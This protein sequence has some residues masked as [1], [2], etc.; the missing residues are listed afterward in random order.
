MVIVLAGCGFQTDRQPG[1]RGPL[2]VAVASDLQAALPSLAKGFQQSGGIEVVFTVGSS[3]NLARQVRQGA[4]FDLFLAAN[5][6]FVADLAKDGIIRPD[7]VHDYGR[8]S[9]VLAVHEPSGS[10]IQTLNDLARPEI[11]RVALANPAFAPYGAAGKQ[12]LE[13][14]GL[15]E[16]VG[17]KVAQA[18]TVRQ[19]FQFVQSGNAEAGLV[20]LAIARAP[21]VRIIA[22]DPELYDP[23][24]QGG[25]IVAQ[26]REPREAERFLRFLLGEAGQRILAGYGFSPPPGSSPEPT[27]P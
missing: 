21:G 26:T 20:G 14:A 16:D 24:I 7:S 25:G 5:R 3:G 2:R 4:P 15:W 17:P 19:A 11:R 8:G 22:V 9:L 12:A 1:E 6:Q 23:I 10:L 18:E 13:R 27:P